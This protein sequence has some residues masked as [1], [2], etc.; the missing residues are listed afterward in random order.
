LVLQHHPNRPL[1]Y[2][3][4]VPSCLCHDPILPTKT[5]SGNPG[6]IQFRV[7][8]YH[9]FHQALEAFKHKHI[10]HNPDDPVILH[11]EEIV[12][13]R[14]SFWRLRDPALAQEFDDDLIELIR[15]AR[16]RVVA[17]VI[18][19]K[20][21]REAY[22]TPAHPYHL[23]IGFMLQRYCGYLNHINKQGDVMSESRGGRENRLLMD[24]Y[25]RHYERG[26]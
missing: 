2:L 5:V 15:E 21:L 9:E 23:A 11:R 17:V 8:E 12:N 22:P 10:P 24:S 6:A 13:R 3:G 14:R 16:F 4:G 26:A 7:G 19:K 25:S 20:A 1:S 18:D